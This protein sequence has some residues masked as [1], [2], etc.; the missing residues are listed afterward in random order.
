ME[1]FLQLNGD[2]L[3][4]SK[5]KTKKEKKCSMVLQ[6]IG[7]IEIVYLFL[8]IRSTPTGTLKINTSYV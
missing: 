2:M 8:Q 5:K 4:Y 6:H 3:G 1:W 7:V